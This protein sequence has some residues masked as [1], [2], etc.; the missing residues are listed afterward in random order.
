MNDE[1][2]MSNVEGMTKFEGSQANYD[3]SSGFVIRH[4]F[5]IRHSSFVI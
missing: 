5:V 2:R 4:C 1:C 3:G